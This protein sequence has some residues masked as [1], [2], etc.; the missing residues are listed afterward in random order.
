MSM[1]PCQANKST[2][3]DIQASLLVLS[4]PLRETTQ[5]AY[6]ATWMLFP[7]ELFNIKEVGV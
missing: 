5:F 1:V 7:V 4:S 6:K 2:V 3:F